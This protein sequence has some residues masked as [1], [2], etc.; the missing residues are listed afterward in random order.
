MKNYTLLKSQEYV[1]MRKVTK[2]EKTIFSLYVQKRYVY[3][4]DFLF[5]KLSKQF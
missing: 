1:F 5:N 4:S 3:E 2:T